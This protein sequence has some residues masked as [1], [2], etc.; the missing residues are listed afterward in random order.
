MSHTHIVL[1]RRDKLPENLSVSVPYSK[2]ISNRLLIIKHL[3]GSQAEIK[4][5]SS[6]DDTVLLQ[7]CLN[8][9]SEKKE[10]S[11][12]CKN[13]GTTL[14]FLIALLSVTDGKWILNA[15]KRMQKRPLLPL[16][17]ILNNLGADIKIKNEK[18][19]FP[20]TVNGK[21]LSGNK[22]IEVK[23][24]LTSQL[25]SALLLISPYIKGGINLILPQNQTSMPYIDMTIELVNRY[26]GNV[27]KTNNTLICKQ[28]AYCYKE[29]EIEADWSSTAFFYTFVSVGKIKNL[30]IENLQKSSLQG[31]SVCKDFFSLLGV[32]TKFDSHGALLSYNTTSAALNSQYEFDLNN[33]PDLFCP[34]VTACYFSGKKSVLKNLQSLRVKESDRLKNMLNE[35]NKLQKRC[36][37][38]QNNAFIKPLDTKGFTNQPYYFTNQPDY[39]INQPDYFHG[40]PSYDFVRLKTYDDHR[41]AMAL[42]AAAFICKHTSIENPACTAKSFPDFWQQTEQFFFEQQKFC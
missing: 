5:L 33:F 2:S 41:M 36:F 10:N 21:E 34:L 24:N 30:R 23:E 38:D 25:I 4:N 31:D 6:S 3:S 22:T 1:T 15:D 40:K 28:S 17:D 20:I 19:I 39:F 35:L 27:K 8:S 16:I 12:Y 14:R 7:Y 32:D 29:T 26:G 9:V 13:A 37:S 18:E 42:S 11:F